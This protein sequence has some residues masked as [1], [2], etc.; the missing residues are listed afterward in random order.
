MPKP[1]IHLYTICKDEEKLATHYLNYYSP[2]VERIVIFDNF[3]TDN[4]IH[5][6][7]QSP[8]VEVRQ[9]NTEGLLRDDLHSIIKS[10]VWK[11]SIGEADWVILT[12][13]DEFIYHPNLYEYL[14]YAK[15]K[16]FSL[17]RTK[18]YNMFSDK[19]PNKSNLITNQIVN[20]VFAPEF[21]KPICLD[22]NRINHLEFGPGAHYAK[23]SGDIHMSQPDLYLLHYRYIGGLPYLRERWKNIGSNLSQVN[24]HNGWGIKRQN[25]NEIIRRYSHVKEKAVQII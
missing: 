25:E 11:E 10:S 16:E 8:K 18:G 6:L 14:S 21:C 1:R 15:K 17:L 22:P 2:I 12:D 13:F 4:T 19:W 23:F 24:L 5:I 9:F 3:S 20:G 7:S